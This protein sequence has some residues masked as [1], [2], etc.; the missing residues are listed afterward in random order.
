[1]KIVVA[2]RRA[3]AEIAGKGAVLVKRRKNPAAGKKP[4]DGVTLPRGAPRGAAIFSDVAWAGIARSLKLSGRELA[5]TRGVFDN[6]T[7]GAMAANLSISEHTIHTHLRR[8]FKKL[9]VTTRT[10]MAVR[11]MQEVL[12]LTLAET[13]GLPPICCYHAK[14]R[15]LVRN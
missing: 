7:E 5:I 12:A 15:C 6:L 14:G 8:L 3:R 10:Q 1:V 2:K 4:G 13:S 11:L 9:R